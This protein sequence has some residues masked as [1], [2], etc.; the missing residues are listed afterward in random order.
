MADL[1]SSKSEMLETEDGYPAD[2]DSRDVGREDSDSADKKNQKPEFDREFL[3]KLSAQEIKDLESRHTSI[4]TLATEKMRLQRAA[5]TELEGL[6]NSSVVKIDK[7]EHESFKTR[8]SETESPD[9]LEDII[10]EINELPSKKAQEA[11]DKKEEEILDMDSPEIK[12]ELAG[13]KDLLEK[14]QTVAYL[15]KKQ[16]NT[17]SKEDD[18]FYKWFEESLAQ[19]PS[20]AKAKALKRDLREHSS[21]GI[22]PRKEFFLSEISLRL[23]KYGVPLDQAKYLAEEGLKERKVFMETIKTMEVFFRNRKD[24]GFYSKEFAN[25]T[26]AEALK[27]SSPE[28]SKAM[29]DRLTAI[30]RKE[31]TGFLKLNNSTIEIGG[32]TIKKVS[33]RSKKHLL[34]YYKDASLEDR[35]IMDWEAIVKNEGDLATELEGIYE[36]HPDLLKLAL[37]SFKSMDFIEKKASL[38]KH[39]KLVESTE[40]NEEKERELIIAAATAK[41]NDAA[42][43]NIIAPGEDKTQGRYIEFF[44][45]PENF[46]NKSTGEENDTKE[47]KKAYD[48]LVSSTPDEKNKNLAAYA[49][50]RKKF[51]QDLDTLEESHPGMSEEDLEDWREPYDNEGWTRREAIQNELSLEIGK[52][53]AKQ[54]ENKDL[55]AKMGIA[56]AEAAND[57]KESEEEEPLTLDEIKEEAQDYLAEKQYGEGLQFILRKNKLLPKEDKDHQDL[58]DFIKVFATLIGMFGTGEAAEEKMAKQ[59]EE[60]VEEATKSHEV[61]EDLDIIQLENINVQGAAQSEKRH[62]GKVETVEDAHERAERESLEGEADD[63]IQADIIRN[64]YEESDFVLDAEEGKGQ[65]VREIDLDKGLDEEEIAPVTEATFGDQPKLD[66]NKGMVEVELVGANGEKLKTDRAEGLQVA[67]QEEAAEKVK[68]IADKKQEGKAVLGQV[69]GKLYSLAEEMAAIRQKQGIT[70]EIVDERTHKKLQSRAG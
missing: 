44:E 32:H 9:K 11:K 37:E 1:N 33:D 38:E 41:I 16:A 27:S 43:N 69:G 20:I 49:V 25:K 28:E 46:K 15:G 31:S 39:Q 57:N 4:E 64:F 50:R 42:E 14:P 59:A 56:D 24:L 22:K 61:S 6:V 45:T 52:K 47:M 68:E 5:E 51:Q 48:N 21:N 63:S 70:E 60:N 53:E 54:T 3:K 67:K 19:Q 10:K 40:E 55:A 13:V 30:G 65:E 58:K 34:D 7:A 8:I 66:L 62:E 12:K 17:D 18:S 26:I 29:S 36:E 2:R 35:E 23:K